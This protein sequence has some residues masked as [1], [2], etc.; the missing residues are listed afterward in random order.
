MVIL[1]AYCGVLTSMLTIPKFE[2]IID[3]LDQLVEDTNMRMTIEE[4][5][6]FAKQFLVR[7]SDP[8]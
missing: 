2:S 4:D 6:Y 1:F 7:L 5:T 8:Y 3:T